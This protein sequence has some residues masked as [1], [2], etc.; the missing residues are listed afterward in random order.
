M[1]ISKRLAQNLIEFVF[2]FPIL[3]IT[4]LV[5]FEVA[6]FWQ[7]VNAVYDLN[8]T[9]N[10]NVA[11]L[12]NSG[13]NLGDECNAAAK[14]KEILEAHDKA[15]TMVDLQYSESTLDGNPPFAYYKYESNKKIKG[16]SKPIVT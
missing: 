9:I 15:I 6:L 3:L 1:Q 14:A 8:S 5:V 13:Y 10:A 4:T 12:D 2:I 11:L 16:Q 7:D